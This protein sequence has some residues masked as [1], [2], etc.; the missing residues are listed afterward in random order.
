[1][2]SSNDDGISSPPLPLAQVI[3]RSSLGWHPHQVMPPMSDGTL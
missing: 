3:E 2:G 1:M